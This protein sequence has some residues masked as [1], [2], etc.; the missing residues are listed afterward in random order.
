M[1]ATA[2]DAMVTYRANNGTALF[3]AAAAAIAASL[4]LSR[5]RPPQPEPCAETEECAGAATVWKWLA[6]LLKTESWLPKALFALTAIGALALF[7][8]W[9]R[10]RAHAFAAVAMFLAIT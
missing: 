6:A 9:F 2:D 3:V 8:D 4:A 1:R 10:V 7:S 5:W